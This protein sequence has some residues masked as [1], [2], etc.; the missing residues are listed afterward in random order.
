MTT[1]GRLGPMGATWQRMGVRERQG[2]LIAGAA[3]GLLLLWLV[4]LRPALATVRNASVERQTLQLQLLQMQR[5]AG[6]A[7]ELRTL[8][9]I[10]ASQAGQALA[11]A[12]QR[13]GERG[14]ITQQGERWVFTFSK[15]QP[16]EVRA[17]LAE[18][19]SGARARAVDA[20]VARG[21][22]GLAGTIAVSS[23]SAP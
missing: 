1:A 12:T 9:P 6:E 15:L 11:A 7:K 20:Q 13:L 16:D 8:P 4:V 23:G 14:K 5:L 10:A 2:L 19:R 18:A 3:V 21:P 22:E 17:W